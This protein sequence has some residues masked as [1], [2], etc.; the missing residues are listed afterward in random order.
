MKIEINLKII[1]LIILFLLFDNINTYLIFMVFIILH[2]LSHLIVGII[3][4]GK[5]KKISLNP[6]GLYLEFYSY[7]KDKSLNKILFYLSG[8]LVN[9]IIANIMYFLKN[10]PCRTEIIYTNLAIG[11]FNL[12]PIIPLDGGKILKELLRLI[13]GF[14]KSLSISMSISKIFLVIITFV[15]SSF[16]IKIQNIMILILILYLWYLYIIEEKKYCIYQSA[17]DSIKKLEKKLK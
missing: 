1:L 10:I 2:E 16:V 9:L 11:V 15:Y 4:G 3:I 6:L 12:I 17:R 7:G 8:S 5:P 13:I 14:D